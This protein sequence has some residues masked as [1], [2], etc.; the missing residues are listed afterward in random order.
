[1]KLARRASLP[2]ILTLLAVGFP[3]DAGAQEADSKPVWDLSYEAIEA[4]VIKVRAGRSLHPAS[5]PN[6]ARVA[7]LLAFDVDNETDNM[8]SGD[9]SIFSMSFHEY[10]ARKGLGR[11]LDALDEQ[12]IPASFFIPTVS[13]RLAPEMV[14][15][16]QKSGRHEIAV[17]GWVHE[18]NSKITAEEEREF[19]R[20][21]VEHI[22]EQTGVRPVGYRA[23]FGDVS[24]NT[25]DIIRDLGFLYD[26]SLLSDDTPYEL[27]QNGKPTGMIELPLSV[28]LEDSILHV[29]NDF[30]GG[31]LTP[32]DVLD[33]WKAEFDRAYEEGTTFLL[34]THP[35]I[36][37]QRSRIVVLE[38]LIAHMK[39]RPNVWFA[40]HRQAAEY[41][42][43]QL[44]TSPSAAK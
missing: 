23:P 27:L 38:K 6:G 19:T 24:E 11:I 41:V 14:P 17:H 29:A 35:H 3:A 13:S 20:R 10:G 34:I 28:V 18:F 4:E 42:K 16:I 7:V 39:S 15:L 12:V 44:E 2:L 31:I 25:L 33:A 1:M 22:E 32:D 37:G 9:M 43:K 5:W 40:T 26:S 30:S 36:I 21:A 8:A